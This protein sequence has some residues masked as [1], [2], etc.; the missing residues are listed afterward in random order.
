M[1]SKLSRCLRMRDAMRV[2]CIE[3]SVSQH[4]EAVAPITMQK[5]KT[6]R[7]WQ[8]NCEKTSGPVLMG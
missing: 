4:T 6:D 7:L 1:D 2:C 8:R 5:K 3:L